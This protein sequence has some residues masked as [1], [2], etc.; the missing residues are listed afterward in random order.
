MLVLI[1]PEIFTVHSWKI[2]DENG[3]VPPKQRH[4]DP[5]HDVEDFKPGTTNA[6]LRRTIEEQ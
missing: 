3:N 4:T 2:V 6:V 5:G 1:G